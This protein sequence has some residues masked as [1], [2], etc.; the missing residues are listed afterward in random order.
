MPNSLFIG[1][2]SGAAGL[3][4]VKNRRPAAVIV[5]AKDAPKMVVFAA[6][7]LQKY[8]EKISGAKLDISSEKPATGSVIYIGESA[9]TRQL[10][11]SLKGLNSDGYKMVSGKGWL[12]LFGRE[13]E[14]SYGMLN[15][16]TQR[17]SYNEQTGISK[18][19][20]TGSLFAV[21]RFLDNECGVRWFMP[22]DLG[23]VV[24]TA[25]NITVGKINISKSPE[26]S[27]RTIFYNDFLEAGVDEA[28]WYRRAGFGA[29]YAVPIIHSFLLLHKYFE[30]HPE[31]FAIIDGE[32]DLNKTCVGQGSLCLSEPGTLTAFVTEARKYFDENPGA[33]VFPVMP[34]DGWE[35]ICECPRCQPKVDKSMGPEGMF[36]DYLWNFVTN[37]A[38]ELQKTHPGKMVGCCA[39]EHYLKPPKSIAK[40]NPNVAVMICKSRYLYWHEK[41]KR[42]TN[43]FIQDWQKHAKTIY[44]WEY[45]LYA[46]GYDLSLRGVPVFFPSLMA[47]DLK[48]LKGVSRGEFVEAE[49]WLGDLGEPARIHRT[50]MTTPNLYITGKLYW[51]TKLNPQKLMDDYCQRFYGAAAK[52]MRS[53]WRTAE[54]IWCDSHQSFREPQPLAS[55]ESISRLYTPERIKA[56]MSCLNDAITLTK[57]SSAERQ[58]IENLKS[59]FEPAAN[60]MANLAKPKLSIP[61]TSV[62]PVIDG[63]IDEPCWQRAAKFEF[64]DI[65]GGKIPYKSSGYAMWDEKNLYL[66]FVNEEP[67]T[68]SM[69]VRQKVKDEGEIWDDECMEIFIESEVKTAGDYYQ[70]IVNPVGTIWDAHFQPGVSNPTKWD[71]GGSIKVVIGD[72]RWTLEASIPFSSMGLTNLQGKSLSVNFFRCQ[73][74]TDPNSTTIRAVWSPVLSSRHYEPSRFGA[75]TLVKS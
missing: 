10:G 20:E 31:Y 49:S 11:L 38:T 5:V 33:Y 50:E 8:I 44:I 23:E 62:A 26:F 36:S 66:A 19:G 3:E 21:Y 71:S 37:V 13:S 6:S 72:K 41:T 4:I 58:R 69:I 42:D 7:E 45:Y 39:Y 54:Q 2:A 57:P 60:R 61:Y 47:E 22:G 55:P 67:L 46:A 29:T 14:P 16:L 15:P 51:D 1:A 25:E 43:L 75:F 53:F 18:N 74:N 48:R 17:W 32:R 12:V 64:S 9:T 70:F 27:Y 40:L 28:L 65:M 30:T 24:P 73:N 35:K 59:Q 56:L 34:N 68:S 52:P 63:S